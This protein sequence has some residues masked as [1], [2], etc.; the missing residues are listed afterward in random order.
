M[1]VRRS[2]LAVI[3][4]CALLL[5]AA[6]I[7]Q[8]PTPSGNVYSLF[9]TLSG[10][11]DIPP[12]D[13]DGFGYAR[14]T[15]DLDANTVCYQLSVARTDV[16]IAAHIHEGAAGVNGP[17]VVPFEA[18]ATG[19]VKGCALVD[20]AL[21]ASIVNNPAGYYVNVHTE[22]YPPGAVRGQLALL[23][24]APAAV[25]EPVHI[26][27]MADGLNSPRGIT[28]YD[29]NVYVA[30]AGMAGDDCVTVGEG[31][32][33]TELC[34]GK[35]GRVSM[36]GEDGT[37]EDV[38]TDV[39][40]Y[41]FSENEYVGPQDVVVDDEGV[42]AIVGLGA[43]AE[44]RDALDENGRTLGLGQVIVAT[45]EGSWF[46]II[47]IAA[48]ES[49]ANPDG[50]VIDSNPFSVAL[51]PDGGAVSDSG[52]NALLWVPNEGDISTL[53][54]FADRMVDA[55]EFLG[56][57]PGTQIP[58]QAVPTGVVQGPDGAFYVGELTGFPFVPGAARVW[59][60]V[61]GEE[62]TVYAEGFTNI[63]DL[64]FDADGTLYVLEITA[65]GL[66][67]TSDDP[68]TLAG[69]L[70]T[71]SPDGTVTEET[72]VSSWLV[73]PAGMAFGEDGDLYISNYGT[74]PGMGQVLEVSW[75]E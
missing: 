73:T 74:M 38:M 28:V 7:A 58:M 16:P 44:D 25:A 51:T 57:P 66:L 47:D 24:G 6:V 10:G 39:P 13:P 46:P 65:G 21:A 43:T 3:M 27:V 41:L 2:V 70:Y 59:R 54:A 17:V 33:E 18:P 8:G 45:G 56:E 1:H 69:A 30:Q 49:V 68:A 5:P 22:A 29:G 35:S 36:I 71:V 55:P 60:V 37:L 19:L 64:A 62:P 34:F 75:P 11:N 4:A 20:P 40:S 53:A 63:I 32:D 14:V 42:Y 67:N 9:A 72:A 15:I 50:G 61:P 23:G 31:E 52:A 26:E 48:Y 12:G